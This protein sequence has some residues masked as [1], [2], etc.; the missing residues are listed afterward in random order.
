MSL[1]KVLELIDKQIIKLQRDF[2]WSGDGNK[3]GLPLKKQETIQKPKRLGGLRVDNMLIKNV[4]LLFKWWW[5]FSQEG[6]PLWKRTMCSIHR[7]DPGKPIIQQQNRRNNGEIWSS[8]MLI[9]W[10]G[11]KFKT[12]II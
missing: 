9:D 7:L 2:F 10:W 4:A 1:F 3:K 6:N 11:N 8:I 12:V 5:K